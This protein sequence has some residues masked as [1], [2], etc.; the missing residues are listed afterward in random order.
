MDGDAD[1]YGI[2]SDHLMINHV[3]G[4]HIW[5]IIYDVAAAAGYAILPVGRAACVPR[6]NMVADLPV[7]LR[8]A[9]IAFKLG[10]R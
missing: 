1:V 2:G 9:M 5:Q 10:E 7:E 4:N 8:A 6:D 3:S